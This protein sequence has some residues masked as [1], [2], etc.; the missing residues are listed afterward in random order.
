ME[1][2]KILAEHSQDLSTLYNEEK[3]ASNNPTDTAPGDKPCQGEVVEPK[4]NGTV[5]GAP[6]PKVKNFGSWE[7]KEFD[8]P[9]G[10]GRIIGPVGYYISWN[11]GDKED[12]RDRKRGGG[13]EAEMGHE[14]TADEM[15]TSGQ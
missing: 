14:E 2:D 3:E 4:G 9:F 10:R 6:R 5:S 1:F 12:E 13:A 7:P 15:E 11:S 8:G